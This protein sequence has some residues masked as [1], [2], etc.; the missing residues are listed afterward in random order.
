MT[1][2]PSP[3]MMT[4]DE[5]LALPDD[6]NR[7]ELVRGELIAM[8]PSA[9]LPAV[10]AGRTLV[11]LGT[12]VLPRGL[13]EVGTAEGGFY[14]F[15]AP[16]TVRAPDV[17]FVS[18][19]RIPTGDAAAHFFDGSP[20]LA[21]E[22]LSPSDRYIDVMAKVREYL[23]AG[24]RLVWVIDPFGRSAAVFGADRNPQLLDEDEALD[25]GDTLPGFSV[26][27]RDLLPA[28]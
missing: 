19:A 15:R 1:T 11:A 4:A 13:G 7:Y 27:L 24:S 21:I 3:R 18:A 5:L 9:Y 6:G 28:A 10:V 17:W 23:A 26:R 25:G 14:L 2:A 22:V 8:S 12:F 20:D 16:D